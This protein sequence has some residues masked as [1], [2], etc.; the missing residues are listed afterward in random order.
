MEGQ[1]E[2]LWTPQDVAAFL[3]VPAKTVYEWRCKDYGPPGRRV[4]RHLRYRPSEV[5][6]WLDDETRAA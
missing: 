3:N 5:I 2:P 1:F 6:A 4:G